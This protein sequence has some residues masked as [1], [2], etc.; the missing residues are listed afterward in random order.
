MRKYSRSLYGFDRGAGPTW[1]LASGAALI[2]TL[3]GACASA[4]SPVVSVT[5]A[6]SAATD[7]PSA[8]DAS[9]ATAMVMPPPRAPGNAAQLR[10]DAPLRYTVQRGDTLWSLANR[11]LLDP[12][13]WPE[14]WIVNDQVRNPHLIYPGDVLSL[15]EVDGRP[16]LTLAGDLERLSPQIR[17][18]PLEA[19]IPTIPI[20]AIRDFLRGPRLVTADELKT[21]PYLLSFVDA[22]LIGGEGAL[23]YVRRLPPVEPWTYAVVRSGQAYK[24]PDDGSILGYEALPIGEAVVREPGDPAT[25]LLSQTYREALV[26][27]HLLPVEPDAFQADFYPHAPTQPVGGRII[28]AFDG[29]SQIS[30]FQIVAINRGSQ[31]GLEP[32]HVLQILQAG[33]RVADPYGKTKV[34]LPDQPAGQLMV[35]KTTPRLSYALVMSVTRPAHLLDRVEAPRARLN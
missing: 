22:H 34:Q 14:I 3:L 17:E 27:D 30:Q 15:I 18:L 35:F 29:I 6:P 21:A 4:P 25:A 19:A 24:D 33:A 28:A 12:W 9:A 5:A 20:D 23:I 11:F 32:G 7:S 16:Q 1:R 8:S 26:G 31:Q 2:A 10:P 13:Q